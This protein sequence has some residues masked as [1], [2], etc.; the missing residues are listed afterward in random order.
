MSNEK[1][2][3]E[4][5]LDIGAY[6]WL[7]RYEHTEHWVDFKAYESIGE[8][9]SVGGSK[10][11][12]KTSSN[13]FTENVDDAEVAING[14]VKWDGCCEMSGPK[15]HFCGRLSVREYTQVMLELHKLCLLLPA[16]DFDCAEYE[17]PSD[18]QSNY[19]EKGIGE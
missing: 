12:R 3:G 4:R 19:E 6:G 13:D 2:K 10:M 11:F 17:W 14:Y 9:H 5:W 15:P 18:V 7:V 16:V 1:T 8:S